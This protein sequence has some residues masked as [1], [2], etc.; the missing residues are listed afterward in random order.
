MGAMPS[1]RKR[2]SLGIL[3]PLLG[4]AAML[5]WPVGAGAQVIG[6][7]ID[8]GEGRA[9]VEAGVDSVEAMLQPLREDPGNRDR[10]FWGLGKLLFWERSYQMG[11]IGEWAKPQSLEWLL[12][13]DDLSDSIAVRLYPLLRDYTERNPEELLTEGRQRFELANITINPPHTRMLGF[14]ITRVGRVTFARADSLIRKEGVTDV[15]GVEDGFLRMLWDW[16]QQYQQCHRDTIE[17]HMSRVSQED[18][19]IA[20]MKPPCPEGERYKIQG[21]FMAYDPETD[22]YNHRFVLVSEECNTQLSIAIP[23]PHFKGFMRE[24]GKLSL[25]RQ[26]Q[27]LEEKTIYR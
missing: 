21:Q 1:Q 3:F 13:T 4:V 19:I 7:K 11:P 27:L 18:W 17:M 15:A 26:R 6:S 14:H 10:L 25:E 23:L 16:L 20:R 24:V 8:M 9:L 2:R 12:V 22:T 5:W